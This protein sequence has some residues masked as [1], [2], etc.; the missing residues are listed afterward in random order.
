MD[1]TWTPYCGAGPGPAELWTR[2]NLDPL[3]LGGLAILGL[4]LILTTGGR[5]RALARRRNH[6][7]LL[8]PDVLARTHAGRLDQPPPLRRN[9]K[10]SILRMS[11][12]ASVFST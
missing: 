6:A 2:W 1:G 12:W 4:A 8:A 5:Q 7:L 9:S 11:S 10:R 3:L